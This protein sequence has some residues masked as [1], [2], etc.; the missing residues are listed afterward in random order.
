MTII[1]LQGLIGARP[2]GVWGEKSKAALLARFANRAAPGHHPADV[3]AAA[4]AWLFL[5]PARRGARGG[6]RRARL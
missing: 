1:E 5:P 4:S 2:D 3:A 6:I